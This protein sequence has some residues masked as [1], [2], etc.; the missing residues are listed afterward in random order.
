MIKTILSVLLLS[1]SLLGM[2]TTLDTTKKLCA[3]LDRKD[4]ISSST[5]FAL[6][7][8]TLQ[9]QYEEHVSLCPLVEKYFQHIR[10]EQES[11]A[12]YKNNTELIRQQ[13]RSE[14]FQQW[15]TIIF[16]VLQQIQ[17][18]EYTQEQV[19][20]IVAKLDEKQ[21]RT[22]YHYTLFFSGKKSEDYIKCVGASMNAADPSH[23]FDCQQFTIAK[24]ETKGC[25]NRLINI[26]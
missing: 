19:S 18:E 2:D 12:E 9:K 25:G 16:G 15:Q 23:W 1:N 26:M 4:F 14:P 20:A 22:G 7:V 11:S 13:F 24:T 6:H 17:R 21:I 3:V 10:D 8:Q 5:A